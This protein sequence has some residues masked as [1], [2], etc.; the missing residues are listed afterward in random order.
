MLMESRDFRFVRFSYL[1]LIRV[2]YKGKIGVFIVV[3]IM[4]LRIVSYCG[5]NFIKREFNFCCLKS[6][7]LDV[8]LL[9]ML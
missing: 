6:C 2:F 4:F 5:G 3:E 1:E 7:V 8:Y 9:N